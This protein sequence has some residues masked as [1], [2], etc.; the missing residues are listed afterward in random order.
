MKNSFKNY[1]AA[2][3]LLLVLALSGCGHKDV[4][5]DAKIIEIFDNKLPEDFSNL[6][7]Y[8]KG[9]VLK[10]SPTDCTYSSMY[11]TIDF[12]KKIVRDYDVRCPILYDIDYLVGV[13]YERANSLLGIEFCNK[14]TANGIYCG[15]YGKD[16]SMVEYDYNCRYYLS[17]NSIDLYDK[18]ISYE[19]KENKD[20]DGVYTMTVENGKVSVPSYMDSVINDNNLNMADNYV[21][22]YEYVVQEGDTLDK[23]SNEFNIKIADL[24]D[25]ND[26]Y[27]GDLIY[28]GDVI[29]VPSL[30]GGFGIN[31]IEY[32]EETDNYYNSESTEL[33][34]YNDLLKGI[35]VSQ[36]NGTIDWDN[37]YNI[38]FAIIRLCDFYNDKE[39][40]NVLSSS[41][42]DKEFIN[43]IEGCR[44][45]N[46]KY[47]IYYF[48][49]ALNREDSILEAKKVIAV[50]R[51]YLGDT[52]I[53][54]PIYIDVE[55]E[56]QQKMCLNGEFDDILDAAALEFEKN[57]F[58]VGVYCNSSQVGKSFFDR[59]KKKYNVWTVHSSTYNDEVSI[60][61]FD[62][63]SVS[64]V[65]NY[66]VGMCQYSQ[67]G[68]CN[69][70]NSNVDIDVAAGYLSEIIEG[71]NFNRVKRIN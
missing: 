8:E 47:G 4:N 14:L 29:V 65:I 7:L 13:Q 2:M 48:S 61:V 38:D 49:R 18:M 16:D 35:D 63:V 42:M 43:N 53:S 57:G 67:K 69:G 59:V 9:I 64:Y 70:I 11:K 54:L 12:I 68:S 58:F 23:I 46:I 17:N 28:P 33:E 41:E 25:Y 34:S 52:Q 66:N 50:L 19:G 55:S 36:H 1:F 10:V 40:S 15:L 24:K 6:I 22:D 51:E 26:I 62:P 44:K 45:N 27:N 3:G 21:N 37:V 31:K 60:K 32:Y 30:Y 71:E 5:K 39:D 56:E 20:Y